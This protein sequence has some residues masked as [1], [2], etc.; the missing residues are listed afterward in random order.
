[1]T[2]NIIISVSHLT[3]RFA[4][5]QAVS[6]VSFSIKKGQVV[7]L[8]G[9]NGAGKTTTI[10]MLIG[11]TTPTSGVIE[12]F[13]RDF[14]MHKQHCLS[15]INFASAYNSLQ[16]RITVG[17]NLEVYA[18][19][20]NVLNSREKII[21]LSRFFEIE[22]LLDK[23]L[24]GLSA[25]QKTRA[26][27]VKALLNDP[28]LLL[29]D[30]PTASLDPDIADKTLSL[31][32]KLKTQKNLS[33][34]YTS[35]NMDEITRICDTVVFLEKGRVVAH[36]TPLN[37]TKRIKK[38]SMKLMFDAE[39]DKVIQTLNDVKCEYNF[40]RDNTVLISHI[41]EK[42]VPTI[43]FKLSKN[44]V[45]IT[46]IEIKKPDLEDVFLQITRKGSI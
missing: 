46:D 33:I 44:D 23:R 42:L 18:M 27:L 30:E 15:R 43:I 34:L 10:Q 45:W 12:M 31:I 39:K 3:K 4:A 21:T 8:L 26:N 22:D 14:Y 32:E 36:D 28:E 38:T 9:A 41:D 20:Y 6:D 35:H 19:L 17:E 24:W 1:M 13:G 11:I 40:I 16:G 2:N 37:L 25:G 7:G 5:T 29:M